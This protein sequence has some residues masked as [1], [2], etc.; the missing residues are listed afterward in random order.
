MLYLHI[1]INIFL[2]LN[3]VCIFVKVVFAILLIQ[4]M[5][6]RTQRLII[7]HLLIRKTRNYTSILQ[8]NLYR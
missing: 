3:I 2:T 6:M 8:L 4:K 1:I 7:L 5:L